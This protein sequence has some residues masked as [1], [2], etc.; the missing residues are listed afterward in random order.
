M[1]KE[2]PNLGR[3]SFLTTAGVA[4]VI[5]LAGCIGNEPEQ[6]DEGGN[7]GNGS[8]S[9]L[10]SGD[11]TIRMQTSTSTTAAYAANQGIA[12]A[13]NE[14]TGN[15]FVEAQTSPGTEANV[16]ALES[17]EAEMV[18]I[19]NWTVADVIEGVE[20]FTNLGFSLNQV[21]HYYDLPWFFCSANQNMES[22]AD[23]SGSTTVSPTPRGSGTAA[24]LEQALDYAVDNYERISIEYGA[25]ASAMN[26]DRLNVGVG[27][28]MNFEIVPGWLQEMMGTVDL[29][30][31]NV[32]NEVIQSWE[33]DD[34][35]MAGSFPGG[36]LENT[37]F[38]PEEVWAPTFAYNFVC[39]NDLTYDT[40]YEFL[41]VLY[42]NRDGLN[43]YHALLAQLEDE[44]FWVENAY[45]DVPF[46]P[47]AADFYEEIGIWNDNFE[48]GEG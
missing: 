22:I 12:A 1:V 35:L 27:T 2:H 45:E 46:H 6:I 24:A 39:R 18:Y 40:V 31:L 15:L 21:F 48:R 33:D 3:R 28:Y 8:D 5:G 25:Q 38:A 20:P 34:R 9:G 36:D 11:G 17:G 7:G 4:G 44:T 47:A 26:E 30:L 13:V 32:P 19:Q 16:G 37:T 41:Q 42:E 23:I 10:N 14:N 29:R 43:E